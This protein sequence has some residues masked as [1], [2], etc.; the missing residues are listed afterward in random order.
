MSWSVTSPIIIISPWQ[1]VQTR[2]SSD[3]WTS[4]TSPVI[5]VL[6]CAGVKNTVNSPISSNSVWVGVSVN[7]KSS[8][9]T[10]LINNSYNDNKSYKL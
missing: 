10:L 7:N 1:T 4:N 8:P 5:N 2:N 9:T 3:N 6:D